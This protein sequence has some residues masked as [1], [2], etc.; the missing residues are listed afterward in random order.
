M[1]PSPPL[2]AVTNV[3]WRSHPVEGATRAIVAGPHLSVT[4]MRTCLLIAASLVCGGCAAGLTDGPTSKTAKTYTGTYSATVV[5]STVTTSLQ[6]GGTFP[7]TN[8]FTFSGTLT[9]TIDDATGGMTGSAQ[10][11]GTQVETAHG[12][13]T[14][15][16]AKGNLTTGWSPPLTGTT[17]ALKFDA[18]NVSANGTYVVTSKTSFTG[19]LANGAVTG[20]LGFSVSGVG[21]IGF[22]AIVQSYSTTMNVTLH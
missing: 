13:G 16:Q 12:G 18:Q 15:C 10:I 1:R 9:M 22:A 7:C 14:S 21:N 17:N 6:G 5:E 19:A 3:A 11:D 20:V 8:T 4:L 2:P